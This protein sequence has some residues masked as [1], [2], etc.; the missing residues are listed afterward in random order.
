M[1]TE[2]PARKPPRHDRRWMFFALFVMVGLLA[3]I[4]FAM[5]AV[6]DYR[7]ARVYEQTECEI[8]SHRMVDTTTF[9]RWSGGS[10]T[11][12]R[13]SHP[14]FTFKYRAGGQVRIASG[15][16]NHDGVMA[17]FEDWRYFA[18]G[19]TYPCWYDPA[20]PDKAVLLRKTEWKFYLGALIP[21]F[22]ILIGGNLMRLALRTKPDYG[23]GARWRGLRLR[24]RLAPTL[25]HQRLTGCL[26][27]IIIVLALALIGIW[28]A[29]WDTRTTQILSPMF[30]LFAI[31]AGIE[32][33]IMYHFI[34]AVRAVGAPEPEVEIDDEPLL[35]AQTTAIN[36][37][38]RGPLKARSY[39]VLLVCEEVSSDT[40]TPVKTT[41]IEHDDLEIR[42]GGDASAR[43]FTANFTVP[44]KAKPSSRELQFIRTWNIRVQRKLD[45]KTELQTDFPFRVLNKDGG[46]QTGNDEADQGAK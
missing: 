14:E 27:S 35:P 46:N 18:D 11:E 2:E 37:L 10:R 3:L 9:F 23:R 29:P 16:D 40:R 19:G 17:D 44:A 45:A 7:I 6:R 15:L 22:F 5:Q 33:F 26:L 36:I 41:I 20:D 28:S 42:D 30:Y 32:G 25:S 13:H 38:Q 8:V 21:A 1:K 12:D 31:V 43:T 24:Y 4:P 34:R 39:K